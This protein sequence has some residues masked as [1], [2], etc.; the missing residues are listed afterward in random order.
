MKK[1]LYLVLLTVSFISCRKV[2]DDRPPTIFE[3]TATPGPSAPAYVPPSCNPGL[4]KLDANSLNF[5]ITF[6]ST[7]TVS[8]N[9]KTLTYYNKTANNDEITVILYPFVKEQSTVY[10]LSGSSGNLGEYYG[11]VELSANAMG[12]DKFPGK[13]ASSLNRKIHLH[14]DKASGN[15]TLAFCESLFE[16]KYPIGGGKFNQNISGKFGFTF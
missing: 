8:I 7:P 2:R 9:N 14:Y 10:A 5:L 16:F 6:P 3:G 12:P 1:Y 15:Y 13:Y 4:N 11:Y